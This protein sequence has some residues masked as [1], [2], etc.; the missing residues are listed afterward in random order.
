MGYRAQEKLTGN[1]QLD[2]FFF[3]DSALH[4]NLYETDLF[5][6]F[7]R[8]GQLYLSSLYIDVW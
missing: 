8:K 5:F 7:V 4:S 6:I 3:P 2:S 1:W